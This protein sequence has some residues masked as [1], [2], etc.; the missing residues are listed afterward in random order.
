MN[1]A[2]VITNARLNDAQVDVRIEWNRI[3]KITPHAEGP[4]VVE[5]GCEH[6]DATGMALLP[7]FY[8]THTHAAMTLLRGFADDMP[9]YEWLNGHIWPMEAKL[10]ERDIRAGVKLAVLEMIKSGTVYFNDMYWNMHVMPSIIEEMGIRATLGVTFIEGMSPDVRQRADRFVEEWST[11]ERIQIA[12]A[13]HAIYTVNSEMLQECASIAR[14][15]EIPLHIH[16]S[17]TSR[18]L[19]ECV[20]Q[21]GMS[22]VAY[23]DRLG[24]LGPDV[25]AAHCVHLLEDDFRIMADRGVVIAHCPCSNMKLS[26]GIFP[27]QKALDA[28]CRVTLGTDGCSSNNNLDMREEMKFAALLAKMNDSPE[29]LPAEKALQIATRE[30]ALASGIDAGVLEEGKLADLLLVRLDE[31]AMTPRHNVI[32]NWVYSANSSI[33][34]TVICNGRILMRN[35]KVDHE[36]EI[37]EEVRKSPILNGCFTIN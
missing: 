36:E 35:R 27:M 12:I 31:P 2:I 10:T 5:D 37:M 24:I 15:R 25:I 11:H 17:E 4:S 13:P 22:P 8:N 7:P 32:S 34:D 14:R 19:E 16:V 6:I 30:G 21:H 28:G 33:I 26:S 9:L 20:V 23:L 1:N 18:E 29:S 3:A